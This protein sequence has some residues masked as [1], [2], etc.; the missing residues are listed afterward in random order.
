M[1]SLVVAGEVRDLW[2]AHGPVLDDALGV[3]DFYSPTVERASPR[4]SVRWPSCRCRSHPSWPRTPPCP[5][6][7][8]RSC[9]PTSTLLWDAAEL[10]VRAQLAYLARR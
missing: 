8:S 4:S 1:R 5:A 2:P 7:S 10:S 3:L 9:T 6:A